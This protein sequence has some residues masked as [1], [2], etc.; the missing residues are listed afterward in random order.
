MTVT[1]LQEHLDSSQTTVDV[2]VAVDR[3]RF[4]NSSTIVYGSEEILGT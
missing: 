2:A 4:L 1:D 3:E